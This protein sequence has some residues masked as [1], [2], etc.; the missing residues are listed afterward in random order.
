MTE[1][2]RTRN[3][4]LSTFLKKKVERLVNRVPNR[5]LWVVNRGDGP[6][7]LCGPG[8]VSMGVVGGVSHRSLHV[9]GVTPLEGALVGVV[10]DTLRVHP[11]RPSRP[12]S[13][14]TVLKAVSL[15]G[16]R[17]VRHTTI[18]GG[19]VFSHR[20]RPSVALKC[21]TPGRTGSQASVKVERVGL[22]RPQFNHV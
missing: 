19:E 3:F 20:G 1:V 4:V 9:T 2:G 21:S 15:A 18:L 6:G 8:S 16:G 14:T 10:S 22:P 5:S 13:V 7:G 17:R 11:F 12:L